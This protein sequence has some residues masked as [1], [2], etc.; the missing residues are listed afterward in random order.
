METKKPAKIGRKQHEWLYGGPDCWK[1]RPYRFTAKQGRPD[2]VLRGLIRKGWMWAERRS[3]QR[4]RPRMDNM[5][6]W[7]PELPHAEYWCG[8]TEKGR[9]VIEARKAQVV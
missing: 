5:D 1:S 8:L 3:V 6:M 4:W 7:G 2:P 9:A